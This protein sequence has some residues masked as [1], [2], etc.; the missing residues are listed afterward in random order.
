MA[1]KK[2]TPNGARAWAMAMVVKARDAA[3]LKGKDPD[4]EAIGLAVAKAIGTLASKRDP[5]APFAVETAL[6]SWCVQLAGVACRVNT[7]TAAIGWNGD[8]VKH[9]IPERVSIP[10]RDATTGATEAGAGQF[11]LWSDAPR[12][13]YFAKLATWERELAERGQNVAVLR[14]GATLLTKYAQAAT[15]REACA[16]DGRDVE[17]FL[18]DPQ[19]V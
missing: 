15:L 2:R 5:I 18:L 12:D 16:L 3:I 11:K 9:P 19:A 6:N 4:G 1:K 8:V 10:K 13:E 17:T 7:V 14:K